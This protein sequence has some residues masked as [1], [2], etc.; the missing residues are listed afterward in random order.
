MGER[1]L[2]IA[3]SGYG[4]MGHMIEELATDFSIDVV[5][6]IDPNI[7]GLPSE[8]SKESLN[9]AQVC[10]DFTHPSTVLDNCRRAASN[11]VNLVIGT[12]GWEQYQTQIFELAQQN[13]IGLLYGSN[14][15]LGMNAFYK[16]VEHAASL[17]SKLTEYDVYGLELHH[18]QKKDSPSGTAK[19]LSKILIK[20]I[21]RKTQAQF[22]MINRKIEPSELHFA[23]IRAGSIPGTHTIGF[24]SNADT[25]ELTHRV[26]N[27]TGFALG[28]LKGALWLQDKQGVYRFSDVFED[29]LN[30]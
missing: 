4:K 5:S 20:H 24:D 13:G 18:N 28:A 22:E 26:R 15:S 30:Q 17:M 7:D 27:R 2:R 1:M 19:E 12:T 21:E 6:I 14:F 8:I 23:S 3:L 16:I 11:K 10:I 9:G 29:I 25:I